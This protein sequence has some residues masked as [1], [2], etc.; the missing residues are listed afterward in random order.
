MTG[1]HS[2]RRPPRVYTCMNP[3]RARARTVLAAVLAIG[4]IPGQSFAQPE[5]PASTTD[6]KVTKKPFEQ[7]Q[8]Q[9][10]QQPT[11]N[12]EAISDADKELARKLFK[13]AEEQK[14]LGDLLKVQGDMEGARKAYTLAAYY[15]LSA[16]THYRHPAFIYNQAQMLRRLQDERT[17]ATY[18][19]Y[20]K[21]DP[22][23][24][25]ADQAR[26][27]LAE[28]QKHREAS[29]QP[30][31]SDSEQLPVDPAKSELLLVEESY[32]WQVILVDLASFTTLVAAV[33]SESPKAT[34][35]GLV[36]LELGGPIVHFSHGNQ[37]AG[38]VSFGLRVLLSGIGATLGNESTDSWKGAAFGAGIGA[39]VGT[40]L[41]VDWFVFSKQRVRAKPMNKITVVPSVSFGSESTFLGLA[42]S[43]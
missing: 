41:T 33:A 40:G 36:G 1:Y 25:H 17:L 34:F 37:G 11:S 38:W 8:E 13:E 42:G 35:M 20:L 12:A 16:F 29:K 5:Q 31:A 9:E 10:P 2:G 32:G 28:Q 43:F 21:L 39:F 30:Q 22:N 15:Y 18:E 26:Q 24:S 19:L 27:Y 3:M 14:E 23:G 4:S 6:K 7:A